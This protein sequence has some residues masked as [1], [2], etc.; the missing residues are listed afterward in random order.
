MSDSASKPV[1]SLRTLRRR[2]L[3][4]RAWCD[5][6]LP[7]DLVDVMLRGDP[8][9]VLFSSNPLQ[10]K[11]RCVVVRH[12]SSRG[13]LLVK[14]HSWGSTWRTLRM[15]FRE[16]AA[17]RC[18]RLGEYLHDRGIP[19]PRPRAYVD[20]RLGPWT[21]RSYLVSDYVEGE[22]LYRHI[23]FGSQS[24]EE[25]RHA[26]QQVARIWES[27]V[28][29][30]ISHNDLKPENFIVDRNFN[31]WLID[32]EKVRIGGK[33]RRLR[34]RQV[35]DV[36]NFL[37]VRGWHRRLEA[38]AI[39]AEA[40]LQTA[41]R[42]WLDAAGVDRVAQLSSS[43][44]AV[45]DPELSV[46]V[47]CQNGVEMLHARQA[48]DSVRDIADEVVLVETRDADH[49]D[50]LKRIDF[51]ALPAAPPLQ[52]KRPAAKPATLPVAR[53]P[54][55]LVLHQN[56]CVT[57]F[58]AKELQQLIAG[59]RA[60]DLVRIPIEKQLFGRSIA[61]RKSEIAPIR[62]FRQS[63]NSIQRSDDLLSIAADAGSTSQ[64]TGLI[65]RCECAT[66]AE[67]VDR[68][69]DETTSAAKSRL[70]QGVRPRF[71]R[72]TWRAASQ[73]IRSYFR[74]DG[75]LS[76]WTGLQVAALQAG[77]GWIEETKLRQM[78]AEFAASDEDA[79]SGE[80]TLSMR[81]AQNSLRTSVVRQ[82]KAA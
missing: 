67:F 49:L 35:F 29:L 62:L 46:L 74:S 42:E 73:F 19:T 64:L 33:A 63:A 32:L 76:G 50:V 20:R 81:P 2:S 43:N 75:I 38:R 6:A 45:A 57:S 47:L 54:W 58:L 36:Q 17:Q 4:R 11:D 44:D 48:I 9:R 79:A 78:A 23:R 1:D 5:A 14:R 40:F 8:D 28:E 55:V 25:L 21:Y 68:L 77:F 61:R 60:T 69:N 53:F 72:A 31:V 24:T 15:A 66:V 70:E 18:A 13:S 82:S 39:F 56:E 12:E 34:Q 71:G 27:L 65:Q 41:Y 3:L 26:A 52:W 37:H 10:V 51:F 80:G 30:G 16:P 7:D 22:S 59:E